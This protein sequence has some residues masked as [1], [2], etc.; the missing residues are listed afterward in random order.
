MRAL[1]IL[2]LVGCSGATRT[3]RE[4]VADQPF[5]DTLTYNVNFGLG[6]DEATL[7]VLEH[8]TADLVFLQ[9]TT[10]AW[11]AATRARVG[12]TY[13]HQ[14]W[15]HGE[16]AGGLAVLS[17]YPLEVTQVLE[18]RSG[19]FP[20]LRVVAKSPL[21]R[22]QA[23]VVHLRPPVSDSGSFVSGYLTTSPLR[24][25]EVE[26]FLAALEP[27][28]PTIV[29]GDFNEGTAG[30]ALGLLEGR[31]FRS[32][33]PE[34]SPSAKTW[35]WD[36][37]SLHLSAQLDHLVYGPGLEPLDARV[38]AGG[39]SDHQAVVARFVAASLAVR[40]PAPHGASLSFSVR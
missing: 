36:V 40:P 8:A 32:A 30:D 12:K 2:L 17:K 21:G 39:R 4:P 5:L 15:L 24:R 16:A 7:D 6:G 13:R 22:V 38:L 25:A 37:G 14:T 10:P 35:G 1:F 28:L 27:G 31:G 11:E 18:N 34:F 29:A 9:E 23:L 26:S 19:W 3:V 33:L 20:A